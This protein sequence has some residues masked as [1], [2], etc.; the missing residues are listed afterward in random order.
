MRTYIQGIIQILPMERT[1]LHEV[2][3]VVVVGAI[4]SDIIICPWYSMVLHSTRL[5]FQ[6]KLN[7]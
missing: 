4:Y 1:S 7:R 2:T 5:F 3:C 6:M